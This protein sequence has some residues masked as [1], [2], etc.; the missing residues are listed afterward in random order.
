MGGNGRQ[1]SHSGKRRNFID[2]LLPLLHSGLYTEETWIKSAVLHPLPQESTKTQVTP[3]ILYKHSGT[4]N[5]WFQATASCRTSR[6]ANT[7]EP[8]TQILTSGKLW[9]TQTNKYECNSCMGSDLRQS[10][11]YLV[12]TAAVTECTTYPE[13]KTTN[14]SLLLA[15]HALSSFTQIMAINWQSQPKI[16]VF[17]LENCICGA[18]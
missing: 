2:L 3:D 1:H 4:A 7:Q 18:E 17:A 6:S 9:H 10:N 14:P 13:Y 8:V 16:E 11:H 15:T 5:L 12:S